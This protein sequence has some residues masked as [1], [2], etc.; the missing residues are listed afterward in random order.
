MSAS[1]TL[2]GNIT[3]QPEVHFAN[4]GVAM[5]TFSIAVNKSKK[6]KDTGEWEKEA[7][8]F[9]V[10]CFGNIAQNVADTFTTGNRIV[11]VGELQQRKYQGQDGTEKTKIE[12]V[13]EEI[14]AS[15][16]WATA[17]ITRNER[18]DDGGNSNYRGNQ[19]TAAPAPRTAPAPATTQTEYE[20]LPF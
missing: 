15:V 12:V 10:V 18:T 3:K 6:N 16:N 2:I 14:A 20:E 11:V 19:Y 8:F 5:C 9:D 13:A 4:S 7:H 17:S 1:S